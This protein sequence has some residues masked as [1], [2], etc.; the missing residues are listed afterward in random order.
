LRQFCVH[1]FACFFYDKISKK[2]RSDSF[3]KN[4]QLT[5]AFRIFAR[6]SDRFLAEFEKGVA[7]TGLDNTEPVTLSCL[8]AV[9][10]NVTYGHAA[11]ANLA[12]IASDVKPAWASR[13]KAW[14]APSWVKWDLNS[15]NFLQPARFSGCTDYGLLAYYILQ[16]AGFDK[17]WDAEQEARFKHMHQALCYVWFAGAWNQGTWAGIGNTIMSKAYPDTAHEHTPWMYPYLTREQHFE[18][19]YADYFDDYVMMEDADGYNQIWTTMMLAWPEFTGRHDHLH[20]PA[21][22]Q[23]LDNFRGYIAPD[24]RIFQYASGLSA[25]YTGLDW[26]AMFERG[27]SLTGDASFRFAAAQIYSSMLRSNIT[28]SSLIRGGEGDNLFWPTVF[29]LLC[30]GF[31]D[32]DQAGSSTDRGGVGICSGSWVNKTMAPTAPQSWGEASSVVHHRREVGELHM[33]D[34]IV[35]VQEKGVY[36]SNRSFVTVEAHTG[37][38]LW[39]SHAID[40][41]CV[42]NFWYGGARFVSSPGKHDSLPDHA[43]LV[44]MRAANHSRESSSGGTNSTRMHSTG[45]A[46]EGDHFPQ[47]NASDMYTPGQWS[48]LFLPT[49]T[50]LPMVDL[51]GPAYLQ[52]NFSA[53]GFSCDNWMNETVTLTI[54]AV[55]IDPPSTDPANKLA[56][57]PKLVIDDFVA[58]A[59]LWDVDGVAKVVPEAVSSSGFALHITCAANT[60]SCGAPV[61]SKKGQPPSCPAGCIYDGGW[62]QSMRTT[63]V[64]RKPSAAHPLPTEFDGGNTIDVREWEA[65]NLKWRLSSNY[66]PPPAGTPMFPLGVQTTAYSPFSNKTLTYFGNEVKQLR[67][68]EGQVPAIQC[69]VPTWAE[70]IGEGEFWPIVDVGDTV[71]ELGD[72]ESAAL[73]DMYSR[74]KVSRG[75]FTSGTSTTRQIIALREGPLLVVDRLLPDAAAEGWVG[76]PSWA[77][78]TGA[79]LQAV[80]SKK[81]PAEWARPNIIQRDAR[82]ATFHGFVDVY[83]NTLSRQDLRVVFPDITTNTSTSNLSTAPSQ[84]SRVG[85]TESYTDSTCAAHQSCPLYPAWF[86]HATQQLHAHQ[87]AI[88]L[89]VLIPVD[90]TASSSTR[91]GAT[92]SPTQDQLRAV[93]DIDGTNIEVQ[94]SVGTSK[95]DCRWSVKRIQKK[96]QGNGLV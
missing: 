39:H 1:F 34:K 59:S 49:H 32:E 92:L 4:Q 62:C 57:A 29:G 22:T 69:K 54:L 71:A 55:T 83:S 14:D 19:V 31:I 75:Y 37:R 15:S 5:P 33:P 28:I 47:R 87:P 72:G 89:S 74:V 25:H 40:T 53:L 24:E 63:H 70:D 81:W 58:T 90:H 8:Y 73:G 51:S 78:T 20:H 65:F 96:R 79:D 76:G 7:E 6:F 82:S 61:T 27:A 64:N 3:H 42:T 52:R 38:S 95:Q 18:K 80:H 50:H 12:G 88:F 56:A 2:S 36:G 11:A 91:V 84:S 60:S 85:I 10:G 43:N 94:V 86:T 17:G 23:L 44:V 48:T 30:G 45:D 46:Y 35:M 93:L 68:M 13:D 26:L 41:T 9:T 77:V 21:V 66:R 16:R 67:G